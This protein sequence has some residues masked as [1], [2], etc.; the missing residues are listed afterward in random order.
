MVKNLAEDKIEL[1]RVYYS[2]C[3]KGK[4]EPEW[5][6]ALSKDEIPEKTRTLF[7]DFAE[8]VYNKEIIKV[9]TRIH[10]LGG[11]I[12][13]ID[14]SDP[15][16]REIPLIEILP[17]MI[18]LDLTKTD[19]FDRY[20]KVIAKKY[21]GDPERW[22]EVFKLNKKTIKDPGKI[23]PGQRIKVRNETGAKTTK[24]SRR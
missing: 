7:K 6:E 18:E 21:L 22:E 17:Q 12:V 4:K 14:D 23:F 19:V 1:N 24:S 9:S 11:K 15:E 20:A 10:K 2:Y 8:T 13:Q 3:S 5:E 16:L